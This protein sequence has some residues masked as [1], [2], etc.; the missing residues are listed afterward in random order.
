MVEL[1]LAWV[2]AGYTN[3]IAG[4]GQP[5]QT[6]VLR[7]DY[8]DDLELIIM[9][10]ALVWKGVF[11]SIISNELAYNVW[12]DFGYFV[13]LHYAKVGRPPWYNEAEHERLLKYWSDPKNYTRYISP[14]SASYVPHAL[15]QD[16]IT[17]VEDVIW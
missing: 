3:S 16:V 5:D 11:R 10:T 4:G 7:T 17:S 6:I 12:G 15:L 1:I 9:N 8:P 2:E 14:T 13:P